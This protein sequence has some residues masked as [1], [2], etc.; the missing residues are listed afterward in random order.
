VPQRRRS[1]DPLAEFSHRLTQIKFILLEIV[2][3]VGFLMW[4]WDKVKHD[5]PFLSPPSAQASTVQC[6]VPENRHSGKN[7]KTGNSQNQ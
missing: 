4:L 3:F 6:F 5:I 2:I 7:G 1:S